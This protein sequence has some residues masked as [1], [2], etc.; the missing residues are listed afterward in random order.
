MEEPSKR[1]NKDGNE[2]RERETECKK[3]PKD[4]KSKGEQTN[5]D[6]QAIYLSTTVM[7]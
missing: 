2:E 5:E 1:N 4:P 3:D 6:P 7:L